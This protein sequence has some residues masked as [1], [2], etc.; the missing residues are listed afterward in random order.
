MDTI[1]PQQVFFNHIKSRLAPHLSMVEEIAE[2]L[3]I[4]NDSAY[5]RI[6]GE[7]PIGLD[8]LQKLCMHYKISLDQLLQLETDTVIFSANL[9]D[10]TTYNLNNYLTDILEN[11][12]SIRALPG[13]QFYCFNKDIPMFYF[14]QFPELASFKCFFWKRTIMNYP[15]LAKK[16]FTGEE[17]DKEMVEIRKKIINTYIQIPSTEIFNEEIV[18][19]SLMQIEF[20][21][22]AN[23]FSDKQILLKIYGQLEELVNHL[24]MQAEKGVK[25]LYNDKPSAASAANNIYINECLLGTNSIYVKA[26]DRQLTI[27][28]HAGINFMSTQ[29]PHFCA[30]TFSNMQNIIRK[31]THISVVGEKERSMFFNVLRERIHEKKKNVL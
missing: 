31:S 3:D 16:Q 10:L 15:E 29:D 6:R 19:V 14:M 8:E 7:K 26:G 13:S 5:R 27:L 2:L 28:N 1:Q 25:Y 21:R 30:Y 4:S 17:P 20:Y 23:V 11:L 24:E 9:G 22:E 12:T 18:T